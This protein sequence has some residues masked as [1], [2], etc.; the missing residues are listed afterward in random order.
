ML[1]SGLTV[2]VSLLTFRI[3]ISARWKVRY[4]ASSAYNQSEPVVS[5][6]CPKGRVTKRT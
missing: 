5:G 4:A 2:I 6:S 1:D 3:E